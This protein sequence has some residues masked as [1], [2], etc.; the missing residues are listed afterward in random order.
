VYG[1]LVLEETMTCRMVGALFILVALTWPGEPLAGEGG[2]KAEPSDCGS[3]ALYHLLRLEGRPIDLDRLTA[4]LPAPGAEG[5]SF[6]DLRDA[7]GRLGLPL[8]AVLLTKQRSAIRAPVLV[9]I[10]GNQEGHFLVVRPVGHTG[11]LVQIIDGERTPIVVDAARLFAS[12]GWTGLALILRRHNYFIITALSI[13]LACFIAIALRVWAR[14]RTWQSA[15][16]DTHGGGS[17]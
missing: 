7:A 16:L 14:R 11:N 4:A 10:K 9:F 6:L 2:R 13:S 15:S 1:I 8:D 17:A 5:L 12:N 3:L